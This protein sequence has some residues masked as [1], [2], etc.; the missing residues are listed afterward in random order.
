MSTATRTDRQ[1]AGSRRDLLAGGTRTTVNDEPRNDSDQ[2][3]T[4]VLDGITAADYLC[5]VRD[6]EPVA[7]GRDLRELN[8]RA[9][10]LGDRIELQLLWE[11]EPPAQ[12]AAA[13]AAGFPLT[14]DVVELLCQPFAAPA[15]T[16]GPRTMRAAMRAARD[17]A[18]VAAAADIRG[19]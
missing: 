10:P 19:H 13:T 2:L 6:P 14:Q 17:V 18:A 1:P 3:L 16:C 4:L 11:G 5:W 8:V 7:L 12:H 9:E 15:G